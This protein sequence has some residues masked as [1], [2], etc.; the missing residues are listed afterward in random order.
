VLALVAC[1]A[2]GLR[3][4]IVSQKEAPSNACGPASILNA[5]LYSRGPLSRLYD[6]VPGETDAAKIRHLLETY[7]NRASVSYEQGARYRKNGIACE[8]VTAVF[9]DLLGALDAPRV[10]GTFLDR[11]EEEATGDHLRRVHE[12]FRASIAAGVPV[13]TSFR[14][15]AAAHD[16]KKKAWLWEGLFQHFVAVIEVQETLDEGEK[17]FR[18]TYVDS[19][20]NRREFGYAR[21]EE[22]RNFTAAKGN[23]ETW[24]WRKNRPF[25]CVTAPS[26]RLKT[27][28]QPWYARTVITLNYGIFRTEAE[29]P[30]R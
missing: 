15:F 5:L 17:G 21:I 3:G 9:N 18:F 12:R 19:D 30:P 28:N 14:S 24:V 22:A 16:E 8:D 11:L 2:P 20:T 23:A 26:L 25:L 4:R 27:Q 1:Q 7:G 13:V 29:T 6:A 10:E